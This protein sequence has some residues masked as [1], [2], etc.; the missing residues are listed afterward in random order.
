MAE[1]KQAAGFEGKIGR[2]RKESIPWWP[3]VARAKTGSPSIVIVFPDDM[4][5]S[6]RT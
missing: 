6:D 4:G 5:Y 1:P 2:T 3:P